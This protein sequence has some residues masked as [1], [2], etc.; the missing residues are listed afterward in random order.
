MGRVAVTGAAGF[1][2]SSFARRALAVRTNWRKMLHAH[3][4][5]RPARAAGMPA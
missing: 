3:L 2:D 4:E 1:S 5:G